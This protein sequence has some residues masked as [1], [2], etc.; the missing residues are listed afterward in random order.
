MILE[1]EELIA[2]VDDFGFLHATCR[3]LRD[4]G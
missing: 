2:P 1:L 3:H 4:L